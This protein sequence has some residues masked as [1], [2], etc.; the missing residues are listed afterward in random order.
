[1]DFKVFVYADDRLIRLINYGIIERGR[2]V[3]K[4]MER[5]ESTVKTM[6]LQFIEPSKRFT[7]LIIPQGGN[8]HIAIDVLS[9]YNENNLNEDK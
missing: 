6:H 4:V 3:N 1:M 2:L 8:N 5:Y 7:D 9:K